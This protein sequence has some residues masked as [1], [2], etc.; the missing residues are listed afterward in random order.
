MGAVIRTRLR[1]GSHFDGWREPP[2]PVGAPSALPDT[3][4]DVDWVHRGASLSPYGGP[5]GPCLDS[6]LDKDWLREDWRGSTDRT[7]VDG[8]PLDLLLRLRLC[9]Q[10]QTEIPIGPGRKAALSV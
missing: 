3:G 8:C 10:M 5:P 7:K 6:G 9:P 2:K 1:D 4:L